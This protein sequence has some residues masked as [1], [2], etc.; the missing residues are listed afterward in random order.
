MHQLL[1]THTLKIFGIYVI[2][3]VQL[4]AQWIQV[5]PNATDF[6]TSQNVTHTNG[7]VT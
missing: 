3:T 6:S 2:A 1:P 4:K 7:F 5:S